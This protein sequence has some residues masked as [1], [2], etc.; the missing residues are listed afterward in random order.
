MSTLLPSSA[1]AGAVL[2]VNVLEQCQLDCG[3]CRPGTATPTANQERLSSEHYARL[4]R[5]LQ[6]LV[7]KVR[8]TGGEPL[9]RP[10]FVEVVSAFRAGLPGVALALTTNGARLLPKLD[11]LVDAGLDSATVHVDSLRPDRYRALMGGGDL[12]AALEAAL[13]AKAALSCVKLNVVVQRGLNEDELG[14]FLGWSART[15]IEVRFIELMNTGSARDFTRAH[16]FSREEMLSMLAVHGAVDTLPRRHPGDPAT[17]HAVA[18]VTFGIISSDSTPFCG[19]CDR[20]RLSPGGELRG[21]MYE[22]AGAP[23]GP[24]LRAHAPLA[25]LRRLLTFA[26]SQKRSY[27]PSR[28]GDPAPFS[29]AQRGG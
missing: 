29:M 24:L 13:E 28:E 27:H 9:L 7:R 21:C 15:G 25:D 19:A 6:G 16:F 12:F 20:L 5:A 10:D 26:C 18:G 2:R 22:R 3:Y 8:F 11:A 14:D 23:L 4:A 17:L 1:P